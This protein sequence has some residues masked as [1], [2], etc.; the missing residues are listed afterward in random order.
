VP[1]VAVITALRVARRARDPDAALFDYAKTEF[2]ELYEIPEAIYP[3]IDWQ[4]VAKEYEGRYTIIP[5]RGAC[6]IFDPESI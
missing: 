2:A 6:Y 5:L 4:S 1:N 3:H